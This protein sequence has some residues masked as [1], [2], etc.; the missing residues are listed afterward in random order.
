MP[1]ATRYARSGSVHIAYQVIGQGPMDLVLVPGWLSHLESVWE[2]PGLARLLERL[3]TFSRLILFDKR[4]TGL[5]DRVPEAELPT[6]EQRMS[7]V[8]AVMEAAGSERAALLGVSEGGPMCA[9]FAATYPERTTALIMYGSY[10]R[11]VRADDYPWAMTREQ[12]EQAMAVFEQRWGEPIGLKVFAPSVAADEGF[13]QRW[14]R[15]LRQSASPAAAV[16]LYRMNIEIDIRHVLPTIHVPTLLIH[17]SGDQVTDVAGS[18]FM[19]E[20]IPGARLVELPGVDHVA[21]VGDSD[22]IVDEIEEFLT[23]ARPVAEP[24]R[25]LATVLFVDMVGSTE[26]AVAMGDRRW[27]EVLTGYREAVRREL[28]R[29][30]GREVDMAGDGFLATFDGPA[31][32]VRCASSVKEAVRPLGLEVRAGLHTGEVELMGDRVAGIAVHIGA[33]VGALADPGEVLVSSTV[34]D[35]VAGSGLRF[36]D[37]GAQA[38]KG[39]PGEWRLFAVER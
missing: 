4:G 31:R 27:R 29:F 8:Q 6:L 22:A 19:A 39:V 18:R 38:L 5:S 1:P 20:R 14:G 3:A 15:L 28:G 21:W 10:P 11:W 12:H 23:G 35:L 24:D 9:L 13:R 25:V 26:R 30:R 34:K 17:R 32:A 36:V 2:E 16:A 37:R 7:D 33:R